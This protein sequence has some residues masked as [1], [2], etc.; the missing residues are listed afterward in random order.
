MQS[1]SAGRAKSPWYLLIND[2][3]LD[4]DSGLSVSTAKAAAAKAT[5]AAKPSASTKS[6]PAA[7]L[8]AETILLQ[9]TVIAA[10]HS[11]AA[12]GLR[13]LLGPLARARIRTRTPV[14][15]RI[16][17]LVVGPVIRGVVASPARVAVTG[18]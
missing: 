5:S 14:S 11:V 4:P 9:L 2:P 3:P 18:A 6:A 7:R 10:F 1:T 17:V 8:A 15:R 16:R 12:I 13:P